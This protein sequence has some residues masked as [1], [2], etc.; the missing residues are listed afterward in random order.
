MSA[1][2]RRR[3]QGFTL[4]EVMVVLVVVAIL[5]AVA[6]PAYQDQMRKARRAE[7][8]DII[9]QI[10]AAQERHRSSN[11]AYAGSLG[12]GGLQRPGLESSPNYTYV[13]SGATANGYTVT[14]TARAKQASDTAC[15]AM[16]AAVAGGTITYG[17]SDA[18]WSR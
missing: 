17:P 11:V 6:V 12:S 3:A 15:A 9:M 1:L 14:A 18:C 8:R 7:A 16:T 2:P 4:I 13:L 10:Q 5:A